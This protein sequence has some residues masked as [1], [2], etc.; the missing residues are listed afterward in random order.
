MERISIGFAAGQTLGLRVEQAAIDTL[1]Q[2]LSGANAWHVIE[3][4]EGAV[5]VR[6]DSVVYLRT[7]KTETKVGFGL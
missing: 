3:A 1:T 6:V 5:T 7:E 4:E 2:A